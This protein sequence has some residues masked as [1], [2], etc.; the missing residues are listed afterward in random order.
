MDDEAAILFA[1][2]RLI[3][4]EGI[5][6]DSC[7]SIE[8]AVSMMQARHY[9]VIIADLRLSGT[10]NQDGL[11]LLRIARDLHPQ[12]WVIL[13]TGYGSP[14]IRAAALLLGAVHYFEKPVLPEVI[15]AA[16]MGLLG[17]VAVSEG[18]VL[19]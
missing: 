2:K 8:E 14:G 12:S 3:E 11:E 4:R 9:Q 17:P 6:V 1:Y 13:V 10:D 15:L 16:L 7:A 18:A 5:G 19:M